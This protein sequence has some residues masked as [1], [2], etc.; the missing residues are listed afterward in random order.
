M[1]DT[2]QLAIFIRGVD[3]NLR[4]TEEILDI[5]SMHGTTTGKDIFENV[6]QSVT[7][8]KLPWDKL[9]GLTTDGALSMCGE[10]SGLVRRMR[11]KMQEENCTDENGH[12]GWRPTLQLLLI[13]R[14]QILLK[15]TGLLK[16]PCL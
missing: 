1:T 2:A 11:V 8:M 6:C 7:D 9:I 13:I 4:V 5:K 16:C 12:L 3:S 15:I 10:R 14:L